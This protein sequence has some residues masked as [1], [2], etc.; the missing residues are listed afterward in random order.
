MN[1]LLTRY[2][3]GSVRKKPPP[4]SLTNPVSSAEWA[5]EFNLS[6]LSALP[7]TID[8]NLP[9][10]N[11]TLIQR[12]RGESKGPG[13][14]VWSGH[15]DECT[16]VFTF[17]PNQE[18]GTISCVDG[19]Y[20]IRTSP[21]GTRL[22]RQLPSSSPPTG[23]QDVAVV[24]GASHELTQSVSFPEAPYSPL[25]D[26]QI[27][28]LI[29]YTPAVT[30]AVGSANVQAEMQ[31]LINVTQQAMINSSSAQ[32]GFPLTDV[33]LVH[34]QEVP[35]GETESMTDDLRYL[36]GLDGTS[37]PVD[38][39]DQ[40]G[41]DIVMLVRESEWNTN[42]GLAYTPGFGGAPQPAD[43]EDYA[44]GVT[45]R[46]CSFDDFPFQHEFAHILGANHNYEDNNNDESTM[47]EDWALAYW[48]NLRRAGKGP[49]GYRTLL[50]NKVTQPVFPRFEICEGE[51]TQ[52]L[53]Y[54]NAEVDVKLED[55][56]VPTGL[57]DV[58]EN[59]R[60]MALV[61]PF[62]W[63]RKPSADRIFANGFD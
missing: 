19:N 47:L 60:T 8:L 57:T 12:N 52:I 31:Q 55:R 59:A 41:A 26:N 34:A 50:S 22:F 24:N 4:E 13:A 46:D 30:Q 62:A 54:A 36:Q 37:L 21:S 25:Q 15:G 56:F 10:R 35:R 3:A 32:T 45:V 40:W 1:P 14:F 11:V 27:E 16:A 38:L 17:Y 63:T 49:I 48:N 5:V 44:V 2:S 20:Q 61:A 33:V 9:D 6:L 7:E 18:L 43:F 29:L 39:R 28:V 51:C 23:R 58:Y 53:H 42:C